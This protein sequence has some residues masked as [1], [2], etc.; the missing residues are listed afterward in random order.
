MINTI[1]KNI[2]S[3]TNMIKSFKLNRK[4]SNAVYPSTIQLT[5]KVS[6]AVIF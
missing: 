4:T 2:S 1:F 6:V 3:V 5:D